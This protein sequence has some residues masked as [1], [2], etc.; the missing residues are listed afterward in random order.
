MGSIGLR[1]YLKNIVVDSVYKDKWLGKIKV[2]GR[3]RSQPDGKI[4]E[5]HFF[6]ISYRSYAVTFLVIFL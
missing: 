1:R 3:L 2:F 4:M 6:W 5:H